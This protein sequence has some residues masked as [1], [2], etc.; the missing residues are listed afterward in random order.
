MRSYELVAARNKVRNPELR[1]FLALLLNVPSRQRLLDL[2]GERCPRADPITQVCKW[3]ADLTDEDSPLLN[4]RFGPDVVPLLECRLRGKGLTE[5]VDRLAKIH[6]RSLEVVEV[7]E[8]RTAI[9]QL[10][11]LP[12]VRPFFADRAPSIARYGARNG[13]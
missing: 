3:L 4:Y 6:R 12:L 11:R 1:H 13:V 10:S 8:I 2:V 9:E 7:E 5:T